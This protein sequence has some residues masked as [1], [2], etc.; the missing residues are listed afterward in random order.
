VTQDLAQDLLEGADAI[1]AFMF[2][3]PRK[4][5][6]VYYLAERGLIPAFKLGETLCARRSTLVAHI[7]AQEAAALRNA[8]A[9]DHA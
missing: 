2:G 3:D 6:R 1:A 8:Q 4:R 5:R 7:Q 9:G